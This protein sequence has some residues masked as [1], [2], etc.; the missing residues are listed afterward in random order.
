MNI[1]I[2][3]IGLKNNYGVIP[4]SPNFDFW[5]PGKKCNYFQGNHNGRAKSLPIN[6]MLENL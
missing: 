6:T 3:L 4:S 5:D 1:D 2:S